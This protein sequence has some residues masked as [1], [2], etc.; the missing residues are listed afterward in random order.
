MPPS[1]RLSFGPRCFSPPTRSQGAGRGGA[2]GAAATHVGSKTG[3]VTAGFGNGRPRR[4]CLRGGAP[5]RRAPAAVPPRIVTPPTA[6]I[7]ATRH[8][9]IPDLVPRVARG[10]PSTASAHAPPPLR[11]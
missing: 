1:D 2:G 3:A 8:H 5:G 7:V 10:P 4:W 11:A 6:P 9:R